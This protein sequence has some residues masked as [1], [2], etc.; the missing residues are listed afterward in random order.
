MQYLDLLGLQQLWT[1]AKAKFAAKGTL[2]NSGITDGYSSIET[3]PIAPIRNLEKG[4]LAD[5]A[6]GKDSHK[7]NTIYVSVD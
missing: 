1:S 3:G 5:I 4:I 2:A 6:T 7:I